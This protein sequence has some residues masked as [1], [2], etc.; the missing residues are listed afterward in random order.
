LAEAYALYDQ[1]RNRQLVVREV[2]QDGGKKVQ[3]RMVYV[4]SGYGPLPYQGGLL[5]QPAYLVDAFA[6]FMYA[7][8]AVA[9]KQ[10][11]K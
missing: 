11:T 9:M 8:R 7:E 2:P 5:D 3:T 4:P 6:Q 10:L 1:C